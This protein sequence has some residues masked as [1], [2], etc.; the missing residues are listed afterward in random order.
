[1]IN[2]FAFQN[3][4]TSKFPSEWQKEGALEELE[5]F[6]Q[7]SWQLREVLY[8]D[9]KITSRQQFIDFDR[10]DGFKTQNYIGTITFRGTQLNIFP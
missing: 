2:A 6:L 10:K 7:N 4:K 1:M 5:Q 8:S 3:V 9:N